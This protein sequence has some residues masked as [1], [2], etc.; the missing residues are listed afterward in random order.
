[1]EVRG[2]IGLKPGGPRFLCGKATD[3]I[4]PVTQRRD[5]SQQEKVLCEVTGSCH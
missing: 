5:S 2:L 3:A 1:M 4:G